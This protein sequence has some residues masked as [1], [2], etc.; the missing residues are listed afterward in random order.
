MQYDV[1]VVDMFNL[2]YRKKNS[3]LEKD[4]ISIARNMVT[5]INNEVMQH[6]TDDGKLFLLYDPIPKT[7]LGLSKTFKYTE[8]Q[9]IVHA[10]KKNR[11]HDRNCLT[12]V[13]LVR[14]NFIHRGSNVISVISDKYE[15]DDYMESIIK[16]N[17]NKD[18]LMI[19]NDE[20]YARYLSPKVEMMNTDNWLNLFTVDSFREKYNFIPSIAGVCV[21]KAC[22]GDCSD[23]IKGALQAKGLRKANDVKLKA[24]EYVKYLGA[25]QD[26]TIDHIEK[27]KNIS[28]SELLKKQNKTIEEDFIYALNM[29]DPKYEVTSTFFSNLLV[30]QSR[31]DDYSKFATAKDVD[32]KYNILIEKTLGFIKKED[33]TFKFG[34]IKG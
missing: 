8:R 4:P 28:H 27:L 24:F 26:V 12:V 25:N 3:S 10:Y 7:D 1:I 33:R 11:T 29:F 34:M 17:E 23:N 16:E 14:K 22:F 5:F 2:F 6:L 19:T 21:W 13:D 31:C 9:E 15:A 20:D 32:E 30:I 18:I